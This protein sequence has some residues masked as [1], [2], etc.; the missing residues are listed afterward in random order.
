M[1]TEERIKQ[2]RAELERANQL[3]YVWNTP[4]ISDRKYDALMDELRSL[5]RAHPELATLESP[6]Q[7]V[8]SDLTTDFQEVAHKRPMLSLGNT[9]NRA[10]VEA[11]YARVAEGLGGEPFKICTELKFDGLSISLT[12]ENGRL[13]RALTRGDG[14]VG[15]DVTTNVRAIVGIPQVIEAEVPQEFEVRG[16]V[17]MPWASFERLNEERAQQGEPLFANPRNAA[18][19]T[20]KNKRQ[21]VVRERGL[22]AYFYFLLGDNIGTTGHYENLQLLRRWGFK[23]FEAMELCT[24]VD[25]LFG[26][27]DKWDTERRALPFATDGVVLK[28][29][30]LEQQARL[31]AT[32][33]SPRWAIA[34]KF[35]AERARTRLKR[36]VFQVGRTGA[37]TPVAEME[38]VLLAGTIVKRASLH[39]EDIMTGLGLHIGDWVYV[40]KAGEIIPQVVA[41]EEDD[42]SE[43][44]LV[45]FPEY[46]PECG[47]RL[48]RPEGGAAHYCPNELACPPQMKGRIEHF[49]SRDAMDIE[50]L[51]PET[52]DEYF[53]RG[54]V[55]DA[56][57]L[58][59]LRVEDLQGDEGTR[60]RSATKIVANIEASKQQPLDRCLYALGL[61]FV[62]KVV[63]KT[64]AHRF[65]TLAALM[66]ATREELLAVDGVGD[67]IAQSV[68]E[69]FADS[70]NQTL[71]RRLLEA[72]VQFAA[73]E[74]KQKPAEGVLAGQT[75][76]ISGVF[77]HHSREEYKTIIEQHGGKNS[78]SVSGKTSFILAG[79]NMGAAKEEK[80]RKL[81]VRIVNEDEFLKILSDEEHI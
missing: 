50:G 13:V 69:Y 29:D 45:S 76:V 64:L 34:Y 3:Y 12:Y 4:E 14:A 31:G 66:A 56:A 6:T 49:I 7:H 36:V 52:I 37:I 17:L 9:Y 54:L 40:E 47:A 21:A 25:E 27:I 39:N 15:N 59:H 1:D 18:A 53:E 51:G 30:G 26:F 22:D 2:L 68:I 16:E 57:D 35:E 44:S 10:D 46:C 23:V 55:R 74:V 70:R 20:L 48:Q 41:V 60:L 80:A 79:A 65:G 5:E 78:G 63:A 28:V 75:I 62:G 61:R 32:A 67:V 38:P 24:S 43:G 19:G 8:G 11:F 81:G 73:V 71:L 77:Q 42:K 33:K 72:G 58:Y